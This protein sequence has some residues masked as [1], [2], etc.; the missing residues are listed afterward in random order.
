[1][2]VATS[3]HGLELVHAKLLPR[4]TFMLTWAMVAS[5]FYFNLMIGVEEVGRTP[6]VKIPVILVFAGVAVLPLVCD[7]PRMFVD[8]FQL[9]FPFWVLTWLAAM[10][11]EWAAAGN[12]FMFW[13]GAPIHGISIFLLT[14]RRRYWLVGFVLLNFLGLASSAPILCAMDSKDSSHFLFAYDTYAQCVLRGYY[15]QTVLLGSMGGSLLFIAVQKLSNYIGALRVAT[16]SRDAHRH[17]PPL[18]LSLP[19]SLNTPPRWTLNA[20]RP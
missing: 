2:S 16:T 3:V 18:S 15:Q 17:C 5:C 1:M 13:L 19:P 14:F 20:S 10:L 11:F 4:V 9:V 6:G 7:T 8:A 12:S